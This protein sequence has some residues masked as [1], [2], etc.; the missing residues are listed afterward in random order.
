MF[1]AQPKIK[2]QS[3]KSTPDSLKQRLK[4]S[5]R[6]HSLGAPGKLTGLGSDF[7][8]VTLQRSV[9]RQRKH[10]QKNVYMKIKLFEKGQRC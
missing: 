9:L 7:V 1:L 2:L 10:A 6:K 8:K 3:F 4:E 5:E